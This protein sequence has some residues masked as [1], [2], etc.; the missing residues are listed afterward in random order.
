MSDYEVRHW[1][2]RVDGLL[3]A[4]VS[5]ESIG[6]TSN[7][8]WVALPPD[9]DEDTLSALLLHARHELAWREKINL[10]FPAGQYKDSI[11]A[12]GF[13]ALRTLLWMKSDETLPDGN[14]KSI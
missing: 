13:H 6:G 10:D 9:G 1:V 3:S 12:A 8:L 11:E 2:T 14:R 7:R 4:V 5:W